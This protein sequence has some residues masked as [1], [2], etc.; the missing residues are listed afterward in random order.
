L[1][2]GGQVVPQ[3]EV[4]IVRLDRTIEYA[5]TS[6]FILLALFSRFLRIHQGA[7]IGAVFSGLDRTR[8]FRSAISAAK[9]RRK[10]A[11]R[12]VSR[13]LQYA[14]IGLAIVPWK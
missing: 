6:R 8:Y 2:Y 12:Q 9:I 11:R 4:V 5:A 7:P 3:Q 13:L 10:I 1:R 14:I